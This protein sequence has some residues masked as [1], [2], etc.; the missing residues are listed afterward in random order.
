VIKEWPW[1]NHTEMLQK[2]PE[3]MAESILA[4]INNPEDQGASEKDA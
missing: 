2:M 3:F 1:N 4:E